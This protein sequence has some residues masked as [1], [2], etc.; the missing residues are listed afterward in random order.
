MFKFPD[1]M[2][3]GKFPR[4]G[5]G[6]HPTPSGGPKERRSL[7]WIG[8]GI[9]LLSAA[10]GADAVWQS[11]EELGSGLFQLLEETIERFLRKSFGLNFH[12]AQMAAAYLD[13]TGVLIIGGYFAR[14]LYGVWR[15]TRDSGY[16]WLNQRR[17]Q[18]ASFWRY[19][20]L[21]TRQWW[22]TLDWLNKLAVAVGFLVMAVP[23]AM[24]LSYGLG[25]MVSEV[26]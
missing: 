26:L 13:A 11:L 18:A 23:A 20:L 22:D 9:F 25:V 16:R 4:I 14:K 21:I 24:L 3:Y 17:Q 12:Q 10:I 6:A 19:R 8:A 1:G 15:R 7:F 2:H 5:S